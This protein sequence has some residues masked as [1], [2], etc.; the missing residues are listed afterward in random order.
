MCVVCGLFPR[1]SSRLLDGFAVLA[2]HHPQLP[3][4]YLAFVGIEPS[5]Q[6][7]GAGGALLR[8]VLARADE[9][10]TT[11]YLET[12]FP[13]TLTFYR[14]LGFEVTAELKPVAGAPPVWTMTRSPSTGITGSDL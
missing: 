12:P 3:H 8:P 7:R 2:E 5:A 11:C 1:A 4:W 9:D 14:R 13:A 6:G 10:R